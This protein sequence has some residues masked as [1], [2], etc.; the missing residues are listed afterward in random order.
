MTRGFTDEDRE[1]GHETDAVTVEDVRAIGATP[2]ALCVEIEGR[3][4]WIPQGQI[5]D[6]S[7]VYEIGHRGKLVITRWIAE[8]K[9]L[10]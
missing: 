9:G 7:E 2:K 5:T 6:D 3:D 8:Q 4:V 10:V 1:R